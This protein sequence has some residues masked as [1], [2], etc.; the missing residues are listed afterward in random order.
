MFCRNLETIIIFGTYGRQDIAKKSF[1]SL[2]ES[3]KN[4]NAQIVVVD[5]ST[6]PNDFFCDQD[7]DY[8]WLPGDVSMAMAR[9]IAYK[10]YQEK[11]V[12]EWVLFA[13]DDLDY[14]ESWY[15]ELLLFAKDTYGKSAPNGLT[16]G[17]FSASQGI[18]NDETVLWDDKN[19]CYCE[20]FGPRADQRLFKASH[21]NNINFKWDNDL[22]GISSY[23]TGTQIHRNTMRGYCSANISN[24]NI[25]KFIEEEESTWQGQRD[26][27]PAAFDKR[28]EG[29][30]STVERAKNLTTERNI[31][32][33]SQIAPQTKKNATQLKFNE[34]M[35][36]NNFLGYLRALI[37]RFFK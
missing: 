27:G 35:K 31:K 33:V 22:L 1:N 6:V 7:C 2:Q 20:F 15:K 10:Y 9:N 23:Q 28:L 17:A 4:F 16:Y 34:K 26:I 24:R 25:C 12:A 19:D 14:K 11:Y 36:K 3:I 29:Y 21:Y 32:K 18:K 8:I 37:R 5:S 30:S 13:E